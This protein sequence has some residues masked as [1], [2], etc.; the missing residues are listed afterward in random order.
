M[1]QIGLHNP[2]V[3]TTAGTG[4]AGQTT[5]DVVSGR[6]R[7]AAARL[8]G[9]DS[10]ECVQF[11]ENIVFERLY[12]ES[13]ADDID[14][15]IASQM[16]TISE[17]LHRSELTALERDEQVTK[18]M[19]FEEKWRKEKNRV[20]RQNG[21]KPGRP[22]GGTRAAARSLGIAENDARRAIKVAALSAEA[23]Q[24]AREVGLDDHRNALLAAAKEET[25]E[26]QVVVLKTRA[27]R[28]PKRAAAPLNDLEARE[29]QVSA[30]MSAWNK[31]SAEAREEFFARIDRPIMDR[32]FG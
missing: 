21:A 15:D 9:W 5:Y 14:T 29:R 23:K 16:W 11:G 17:N 13:G 22:T 26:A 24:A 32:R 20:L 19:E 10:I 8:L 3:V 18:W 25:A 4:P 27:A 31:A 30:L 7:V 28:K 12:L 2:V 1:D 6:H